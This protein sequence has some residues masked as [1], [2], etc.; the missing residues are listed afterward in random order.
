MLEGI[1]PLPGMTMTPAKWNEEG[2]EEGVASTLT[3][4]AR[5]GDRLG[6]LTWI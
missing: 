4:K 1:Q 6:D 3:G 5:E 2:D